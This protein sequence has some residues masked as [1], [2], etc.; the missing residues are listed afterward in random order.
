M[1]NLE[2]EHAEIEYQ[3]RCLMLQPDS[4]KT[5]SD[6]TKEEELLRRYVYLFEG[7]SVEVGALRR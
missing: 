7:A 6:K 4:N 1:H 5:D 2:E 3:Y